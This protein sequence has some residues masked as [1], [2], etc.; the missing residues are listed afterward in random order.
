MCM[1]YTMHGLWSS[2]QIYDVYDIYD[3]WFI[4]LF[5]YLFGPYLL[6]PIY[7]YLLCLLE[8][9]YLGERQGERIGRHVAKTPL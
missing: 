7:V 8:L 1:I 4:Y 6:A 9:G 5:I 2:L 3:L